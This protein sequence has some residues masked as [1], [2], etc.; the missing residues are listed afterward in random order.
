VGAYSA[1]PNPSWILGALLL[2]EGEKRRGGKREGAVR[3]GKG[4]DAQGLVDTLMFQILTNADNHH[5]RCSAGGG[6]S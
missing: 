3:G 1:P 6:R 4:G 5:H 2:R